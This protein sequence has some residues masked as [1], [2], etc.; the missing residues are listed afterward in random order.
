MDYDKLR[1]EHPEVISM[2]QF[3]RICRISK[4][5]ARWI[6]ENGVVPCRDSG[7][8]TRRFQIRL[9]DVIVFLRKRDDGLLEGVIPVGGFSSGSGTV[10]Q[11]QYELDSGELCSYLL[12]QWQA[13]PDMLTTKQ[14]ATLCGYTMYT[15]TRW[16]QDG[17]VKAVLY[18]RKYLVSKGSLAEFLSSGAGQGIT[19]MSQTHR[20]LMDDFSAQ[21]Q[22][23]AMELGSM[24]L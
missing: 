17:L 5:K 14:A 23:S 6:L 7:K 24:A 4:Q 8:K 18:Y 10:S 22:N 20:D 9:E 13:E 3:Y 1:E 2:E 21:Q 12:E 19:A 16:A 11:P 15:M